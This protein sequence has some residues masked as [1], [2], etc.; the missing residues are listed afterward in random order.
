MDKLNNYKN[1]EVVEIFGDHLVNTTVLKKYPVVI[2]AGVHNGEEIEDLYNLVPELKMY[3]IEPSNKCFFPIKEKYE[4]NNIDWFNNA[5]IS[6]KRRT[7]KHKL[8]GTYPK[9]G[10]VDW[11]GGNGSTRFGYGGIQELQAHDVSNLSIYSVKGITVSRILE[12]M[13]ESTVGFFKADIEGA[14]YEVM[15]DWNKE[16]S[17]TIRQISI[18]YGNIQV[19]KNRRS[20]QNV[21]YDIVQKL[22]TLGYYV[23]VHQ[24]RVDGGSLY[25][26]RS[27]DCI[28]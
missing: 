25:A 28:S 9:L 18:E 7:E 27:D 21:R 12:L 26:I 2:N 14:E 11:H 4:D 17:N 20:H 1:F 5:L 6:E 19:G 16:I 8:T 22:E 10:F 23:T 24:V 13:P 15:M 3:A